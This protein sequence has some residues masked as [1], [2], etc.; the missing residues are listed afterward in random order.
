VHR[1]QQHVNESLQ[2]GTQFFHKLQRKVFKV[3]GISSKMDGN[4]DFM[5]SDTD[6]ES[7]SNDSHDDSSIGSDSE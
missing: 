1:F 4:E 5:I 7:D 2:H 6:N 3:T